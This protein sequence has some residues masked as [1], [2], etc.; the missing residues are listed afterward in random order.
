[1]SKIIIGI[2]QATLSGFCVMN[3]HKEILEVGTKNNNSLLEHKLF[4]SS[5][6]DKYQE[7]HELY[8]LFEDIQLQRNVAT[9]KN[10]A[11]LQGVYITTLLEKGI[12]YEITSPSHWRMLNKIGKR[13]RAEAKREAKELCQQLWPNEHFTL[14]S[15]E[16]T[17]IANSYFCG[18]VHF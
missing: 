13:T 8:V 3:E 17:L 4:L 18:K 12:E 16:A 5:L 14:D 6:L 1:M 10:L 9:F 11:Q 7:E 15:A 2:D